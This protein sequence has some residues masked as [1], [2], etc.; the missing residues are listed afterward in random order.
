MTPA[1]GWVKTGH[2]AGY[3]NFYPEVP[4]S[5][6]GDTRYILKHVCDILPMRA[7]SYF[8][9]TKNKIGVR[10]MTDTEKL[11]FDVMEADFDKTVLERSRTLPVLVDFWA[12]WCAPCRML[13]PVLEEL[14]GEYGGRIA[15]A[16]VDVDSNQSLAGQY[17]I[18]SIP[19]V[20]I[21]F[22]GDVVSEFVGALPPDQIREKIEAIL[23]DEKSPLIEEANHYMSGGRWEEAEKIYSKILE[24]DSAQP[25]ANL[26]MGMIAYH[27]GR[28]DE[29]KKYLSS[30][31]D[32][33]PGYDKAIP[34]LA[35]IYFEKYEVSDLNKITATLKDSPNDC[36]ALF[37]LAIIYAKGG[38]YE[39]A[40]DMLIQVLKVKK[41]WDEGAAREAYLKIIE[42]LGRSSPEGKKYERELS[43]LLFS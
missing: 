43:M 1:V 24:E 35:R 18:Q 15:L 23:P 31:T 7:N 41:D 3:V 2:F 32:E 29:A 21:F 42:I 30:V 9:V 22:G 36:R 19:A 6:F 16:K 12:E 26:G 40:L 25:S 10:E 27:Q 13:G 11:I 34:M 33:T 14:V 4:K 8:P 28:F 5:F 20:K 38:E 37:S 17:G 39:R